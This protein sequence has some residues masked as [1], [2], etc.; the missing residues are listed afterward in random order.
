V[1]EQEVV[2]ELE[3]ELEKLSVADVLLHTAS[4]VATLAY[5]KLAATERDLEQVRLAIDS[6]Q[7]L[8]PLLGRSVPMHVERDFRQAIANLQLAYAEA[9]RRVQ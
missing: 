6:L 3:A 8:V 5:R 4:T 1:T 7:A 9:V 2:A